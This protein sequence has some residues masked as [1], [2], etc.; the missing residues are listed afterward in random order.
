MIPCFTIIGSHPI[1]SQR[2]KSQPHMNE[3]ILHKPTSSQTKSA[4]TGCGTSGSV[5]CR[6]R[7]LDGWMERVSF[8]RVFTTF[9]L[10]EPELKRFRGRHLC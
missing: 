8:S 1:V 3:F 6:A 2:I 4:R 5:A 9:A 7:R 10:K